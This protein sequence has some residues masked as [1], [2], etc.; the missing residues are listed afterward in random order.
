ML[1]HT[2]RH[3]PGIGPANEGRLW[4]HGILSWADWPTT[5]RL[6]IAL[7]GASRLQVEDML[8]RSEEALA[9]GD[10]G[11]FAAL[12]KPSDCW[13]LF[14]DFRG[15][16]AYLDIETSGLDEH[17]EVTVITLYDGFTA[18]RYVGGDN[19]D[20]NLD[21][22]A[23]DVMGYTLLISYGGRRFDIPF[24]ERALGLR[25][26]RAQ[27]DL[28]PVL[29]S[30][31]YRGGLKKTEQALGIDRGPLRGVDGLTAVYLWRRYRESGDRRFLETLSAYNFA[32]TVNLERLLC[33]ACEMKLAAT[34]FADEFILPPPP[35]PENPY[36]V[37]RQCLP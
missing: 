16:A 6:P 34:P 29:H 31:G 13:R 14:F 8:R 11:F 36:Q 32:D 27:I 24:L 23:T 17:A 30:L 10:V 35:A 20:A 25:L 19:L 2:F 15:Q 3:L 37:Y 18:R 1:T 33:I 12:L 21:T 9:A 22:F 26:P 7:S 5:R 4:R 28:C